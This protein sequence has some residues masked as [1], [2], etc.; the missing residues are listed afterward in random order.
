MTETN[1]FDN[2]LVIEAINEAGKELF[3]RSQRKN[4]TIEERVESIE[5]KVDEILEIF[6]KNQQEKGHNRKLPN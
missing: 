2:S 1:L 5:K 6:Q 3:Q 4:L